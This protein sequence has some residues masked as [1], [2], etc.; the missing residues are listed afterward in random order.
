MRLE[1]EEVGEELMRVLFVSSHFP[2]D[3]SRSVHGVFQRMRMWLDAIQSLNPD[4]DI[5]FF[6]S[7]NG[8]ASTSQAAS[9]VTQQLT[10]FWGI[11]SNVTLCEREPEECPSGLLASYVQPALRLSWRPDFR[12]YLGKRQTEAFARC[13]ARSP[14]IVFFHRLHTTAAATS[15]SFGGVRTFI[16][17][18]DVEHLR[19]AREVAQ[20]PW[21]RSKPLLYL[22]VPALWWGERRA[23]VRSHCAFVCSEVDRHYL[24]RVMKVHNV[25]VI[26]NAVIRIADSS[27]TTEPNVL[28]IGTFSYAPNVVAIEYLIKEVWPHLVRISPKARLLIAGPRSEVIPSFQNPP[29]GVE[30]LGFVPDLNALYRKTRVFC[31]PIQ[32][33]GGTRIKILEAASYG[34]PVVSTQIGAEGLELV[35]D[36]EIVLR[37]DAVGIAEAC[38]DLLEDDQR[39]ARIGAAGRERVRLQYSRDVVVR[40][41]SAI[42]A[43]DAAF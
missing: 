6:L 28:F 16:D 3:F 7:P 5:L 37:N 26:P 29:A 27:L 33:G 22:Q 35:P 41:M 15:L 31:C 10:E 20:P 43:G 9:M 23:I 8:I 18:D 14:D 34:V 36:K 1:T 2:R 12:P 11:R 4:L 32:S 21:W 24:R 17:L 13:L 42:L 39:A 30:F 40:R 38:A 25:E 19:F